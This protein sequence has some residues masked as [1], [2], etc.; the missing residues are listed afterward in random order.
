MQKIT[1]LFANKR[2]RHTYV[3]PRRYTSLADLTDKRIACEAHLTEDVDARLIATDLNYLSCEKVSH[4]FNGSNW[5]DAIGL[6]G[7]GSQLGTGL[8]AHPFRM[9]MVYNY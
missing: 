1:E 8:L 2:W 5:E 7:K 6:C 4:G 9:I 3:S